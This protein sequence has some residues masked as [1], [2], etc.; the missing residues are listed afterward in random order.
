MAT[1]LDVALDWHRGQLRDCLEAINRL[2]AD[3]EVLTRA[4][5]LHHLRQRETGL[6]ATIAHLEGLGNRSR[7]GV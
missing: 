1:A 2:E 4:A 7:A 3:L 5:E 6:N